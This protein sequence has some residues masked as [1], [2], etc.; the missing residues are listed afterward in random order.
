[1]AN[2]PYRLSS[3]PLD[4]IESFLL[5]N[6]FPYRNLTPYV[7]ARPDTR[8]SALDDYRACLLKILSIFSTRSLR[9]SHFVNLGLALIAHVIHQI[10]NESTR[11]RLKV[12]TARHMAN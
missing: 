5:I 10:Q 11:I 2:Q 3:L 4:C 9:Q 8:N 6:S 1:M 12:A 7:Q